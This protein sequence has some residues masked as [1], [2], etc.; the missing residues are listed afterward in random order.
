MRELTLSTPGGDPRAHVLELLRAHGYNTT[1]FQTLEP[2]LE[3]FF[4]GDE[5]CVAYVDTGA[6]WV[7][8]GAPIA[9][10]SRLDDT[11]AQFVAC[12]RARGRRACFFGAETR[13]ANASSLAR[14]AVAAQPIWD[15][16]EWAARARR[17][18]V[19]EQLRRARAK[20]VSVVRLTPEELAT[21]RVRDELGAA[22]STWLSTRRMPPMRFLV[23][24]D[25]LQFPRERA[26]WVARRDGELAGVLGAVPV[27]LKQGWF[28]EDL[29]RLP[30]AP[31]GTAELLV[32]TA[33]REFAAMD[34]RWATLG[35]VPLSG[36]G[37]WLRVVR[38]IGAR[39]YDFG[40]LERFRAKLDPLR[41]DP[42]FLLRPRGVSFVRA[43][44]DVLCAFAGTSLVR[45][46]I[47]TL[48]RGRARPA[49]R[50]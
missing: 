2:S 39:V 34:C 23:D 25:L 21:Q 48:L 47:A 42:I 38:A 43:I 27:Y 24:V 41:T 18:S 30:S 10:L 45:F 29:L 13:F 17:R 8:A 7:A 33:M 5:A 44:L 50:A 37:G 35:M 36:V 19:R 12:A 16:K 4:A 1:G 20:G 11:A 15:P 46:G 3:Y 32:D 49:L 28:C 9:E 31:N 22:T 14:D 26:V 6:A 40:G